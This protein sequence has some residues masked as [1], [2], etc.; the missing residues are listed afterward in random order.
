MSLI[1]YTAC[2]GF[3]FFEKFSSKKDFEIFRFFD[4]NSIEKNRKKGIFFLQRS[5]PYKC[6]CWE[7][8]Q[9]FWLVAKPEKSK[10]EWFYF[11]WYNFL[12]IFL[13]TPKEVTLKKDKIYSLYTFF[14]FRSFFDEKRPLIFRFSKKLIFR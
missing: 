9:H 10:N 13:W 6:G 7:N 8:V 4:K 3:G 5:F 1:K 14:V 11:G 2:I 12:E